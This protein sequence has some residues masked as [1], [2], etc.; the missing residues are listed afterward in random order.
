MTAATWEARLNQMFIYT[1]QQ[2]LH[3]PHT[4]KDIAIERR[5]EYVI[6]N[7]TDGENKMFQKWQVLFT[8]QHHLWQIWYCKLWRNS[9]TAT[10][11][12]GLFK[13]LAE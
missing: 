4:A 3:K 6:M 7:R 11:Y 2:L 9:T 8:K 5:L 13:Y 10:H 12:V 1:S